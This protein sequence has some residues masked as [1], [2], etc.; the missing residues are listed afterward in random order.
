[1]HDTVSSKA[2]RSIQKK[3]TSQLDLGGSGKLSKGEL[4]FLLHYLYLTD[5]EFIEVL[6]ALD[7]K[8]QGYV[9]IGELLFLFGSLF[10]SRAVE[11]IVM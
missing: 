8:R 5:S 10:L 6:R 1:M 2:M 9:D 4:R 7:L 3:F 11:D